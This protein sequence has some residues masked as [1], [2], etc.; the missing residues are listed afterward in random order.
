[1]W[2]GSHD[3][4]GA[5]GATA[6]NPGYTGAP[7]GRG[8]YPSELCFPPINPVAYTD[9][10]FGEVKASSLLL[11]CVNALGTCFQKV[12]LPLRDHTEVFMNEMT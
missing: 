12:F 8:L 4:G 7:P 9:H 2:L 1:M 5:T 6:L 11:S 3:A 10:T